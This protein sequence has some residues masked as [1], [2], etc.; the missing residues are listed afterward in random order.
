LRWRRSI[1]LWAMDPVTAQVRGTWLRA[2]DL[3]VGG[4]IGGCIGFAIHA[5]GL[6]FAFG[7]TVLPV[8][9]GRELCSSLRMV[10]WCAW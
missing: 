2:L 3:A 8:L 10:W 7:V 6:L 4:W 9:L 5:T 1:V